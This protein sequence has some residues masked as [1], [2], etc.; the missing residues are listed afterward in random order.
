MAKKQAVSTIDLV[1]G[2]RRAEQ[3]QRGA[4]ARDG[5]GVR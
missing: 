3:G 4:A 5:D 2:Q 1:G